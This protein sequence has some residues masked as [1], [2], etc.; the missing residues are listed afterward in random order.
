MGPQGAAA[1]I[2]LERVYSLCSEYVM[3]YYIYIYRPNPHP[4]RAEA[5]WFHSWGQVIHFPSNSQFPTSIPVF[6]TAQKLKLRCGLVSDASTC[7]LVSD[8][9]TC[10]AGGPNPHISRIHQ[11]TRK[12]RRIYG[13]SR[14]G[15]TRAAQTR[16]IHI[17]IY[18]HL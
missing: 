14:I 10:G 18:S 12:P 7:G 8:A 11:K 13:M 17:F 4:N 16:W 6:K 1:G 2:F 5:T 15:K 3:L 9:S